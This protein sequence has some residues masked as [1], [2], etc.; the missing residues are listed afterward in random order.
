VDHVQGRGRASVL[1]YGDTHEGAVARV[2]ALALRV[3]AE[4]LEHG[5]AGPDLWVVRLLALLVRMGLRRDLAT[6]LEEDRIDLEERAQSPRGE[7]RAPPCRA[8][9][10]A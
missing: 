5:E 3:I 2:Q 4:R 10:G 7:E 8:M 6:A 9:L 1:A